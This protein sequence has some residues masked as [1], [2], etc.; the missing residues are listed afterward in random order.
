VRSTIARP[1]CIIVI[2]MTTRSATSDDGLEPAVVGSI[3]VAG[4]RLEIL[5][6][7]EGP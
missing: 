7:E 1:S 4:V 3:P 6:S 2:H 5:S